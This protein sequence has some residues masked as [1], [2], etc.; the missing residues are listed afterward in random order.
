MHSRY[1][2]HAGQTRPTAGFLFF[3]LY[4]PMAGS[5]PKPVWIPSDRPNACTGVCGG[6][7]G[8]LTTNG[9]RRRNRR[10]ASKTAIR[11]STDTRNRLVVVF[12]CENAIGRTGQ[13]PPDLLAQV[14]RQRRTRQTVEHWLRIVAMHGGLRFRDALREP[15]WRDAA[16]AELDLLT[17]AA[18]LNECTDSESEALTKCRGHVVYAVYGLHNKRIKDCFGR[19]SRRR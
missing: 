3:R 15:D 19:A 9:H 11:L 4:A 14:G 12:A 1:G 5:V 2:Y 18:D 13:I 10:I 17:V 16:T 7:R 6:N 8:A